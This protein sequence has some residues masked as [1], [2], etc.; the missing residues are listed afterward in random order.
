M[1]HQSHFVFFSAQVQ[2]LAL[3][4]QQGAL[5]S[6]LSQSQLQSLSLKQWPGASAELSVTSQQVARL[7]SAGTEPNSQ[8]AAAKSS[9]AE[10]PS[11]TVGKNYKTS[12][13]TTTELNMCPNVTSVAGHPLISTGKP[14]QSRCCLY[15]Q[16]QWKCSVSIVLLMEEWKQQEKLKCEGHLALSIKWG[17]RLLWEHTGCVCVYLWLVGFSICLRPPKSS[18]KD[19]FYHRDRCTTFLVQQHNFPHVLIKWDARKLTHK[20]LTFKKWYKQYLI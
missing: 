19:I 12:D 17:V 4:G 7:R 13:L 18:W 11:E 15:M 10:M 5:T 1:L 14:S 6:S 2:N 20:L 16:I 8:G 9:P 3:R